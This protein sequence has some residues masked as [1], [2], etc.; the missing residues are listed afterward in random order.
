MRAAPII[1]ALAL[2]SAVLA[3]RDDRSI[4]FDED[5]NF[6]S[7][8]T[9]TLSD[10]QMT[11]ERPELKFPIVIKTIGDTIR[12]ALTA[13]GLKEVPLRPDLVVEYSVDAVDWGIG[14]FGR[15]TPVLPPGARGGRG[16]GMQVDFTE[17][18]L[19]IDLKHGDPGL[20]VWRG[21]YRDAENVASK[22]ADALPGDAKTLLSQYPP[23]KT[24]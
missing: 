18:T 20:L 23:K 10:G 9:F 24:E 14:P 3:A 5:A 8:K 4:L 7:F 16:R 13:R 12:A 11:S 19:V 15:A 1:V 2:S 22:L 21:V 17:A 6:P